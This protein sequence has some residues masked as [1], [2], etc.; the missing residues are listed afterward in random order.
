M[1]RELQHKEEV[2]M[3]ENMLLFKPQGFNAETWA[4]KYPTPLQRE[5]DAMLE[6]VGLLQSEALACHDRTPSA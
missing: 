1:I 5:S 3:E 2:L 6:W 4:S